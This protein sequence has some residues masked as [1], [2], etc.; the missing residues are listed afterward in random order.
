MIKMSYMYI[1][2]RAN[3]SHAIV[4]KRSADLFIIKQLLLS[5]ERK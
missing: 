2:I 5:L 1:A 3:I 4:F